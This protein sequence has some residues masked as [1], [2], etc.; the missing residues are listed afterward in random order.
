MM[1][2]R[3]CQRYP[4][5]RPS[6]YIKL[7]G[8]EGLRFDLACAYLGEFSDYDRQYAMLDEIL[9]GS[10]AIVSSLTGKKVKMPK[11]QKLVNEPEPIKSVEELKKELIT[12]GTVL[13]EIDGRR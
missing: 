5:R 11:R 7:T 10:Y 4:N 8:W 12:S 13:E 2:D 6:D 1:L 9:Q 3:V